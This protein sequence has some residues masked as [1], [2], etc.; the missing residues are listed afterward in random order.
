M[1]TFSPILP[2]TVWPQCSPDKREN[3]TQK[4]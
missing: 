4:M 1:Y 2:Y 3:S